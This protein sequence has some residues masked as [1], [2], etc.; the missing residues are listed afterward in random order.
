M[1]FVCDVQEKNVD[2]LENNVYML[3]AISIPIFRVQGRKRVFA[4]ATGKRVLPLHLH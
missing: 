2:T 4:R 3:Q 1:P